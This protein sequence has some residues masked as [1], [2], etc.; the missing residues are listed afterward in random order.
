MSI[1]PNVWTSPNCAER[2]CSS[3]PRGRSALSPGITRSFRPPPSISP[4]RPTT[5]DR[6]R[7]SFIT[8]P[9]TERKSRTWSVS[10]GRAL[11]LAV[12]EPGSRAPGRPRTSAAAQGAGFS[13]GPS[14]LIVSPVSR[15]TAFTTAIRGLGS[16]IGRWGLSGTPPG[17]L[18]ADGQSARHG[19]GHHG[20]AGAGEST[21][22]SHH[23]PPAHG[24]SN[25][26]QA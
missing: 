5:R 21:E 15:V 8:L 13:T 1:K 6:L 24:R 14:R 17:P 2:A 26:R 18:K 20:G 16:L 10:P 19:E 25:P 11:T 9:R 12:R 7:L 4:P 22:P 23:R 3:Y